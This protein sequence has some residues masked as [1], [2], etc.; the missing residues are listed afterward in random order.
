LSIVDIVLTLIILAGAYG[1]YKDG[2]LISL[3][4]FIAIILGVLG[5]FK[6]MGSAM[7][8]LG[9][10]YKV[11]ESI[12]PYAAFGLVFIVIVI[13]VGLLGRL[14]KAAIQKSLLGPVDQIAGALFGIAKVAFMLSIILWITDSLKLRLPEELTANSWL[15]PAIANFAVEVTQLIGGFLPFLDDTIAGT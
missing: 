5:G 11:D 6:L 14:I 7:I 1:G 13:C 2:L 4:S 12:L 15:Q 8:L 3:F 10:N 9:Q